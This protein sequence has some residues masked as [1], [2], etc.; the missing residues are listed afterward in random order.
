MSSLRKSGA[1]TAFKF[2]TPIHT[3]QRQKHATLCFWAGRRVT[4]VSFIE[5]EWATQCNAFGNGRIAHGQLCRRRQFQRCQF[6]L[7]ISTGDTLHIGSS[8]ECIATL[9]NGAYVNGSGCQIT[10]AGSFVGAA[11]GLM[12]GIYLV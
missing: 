6:G 8:A 12:L 2:S 1:N 11:N 7:N 10:V 3:M 9:G 5:V 4:C